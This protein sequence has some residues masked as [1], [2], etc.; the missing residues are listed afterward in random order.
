VCHPY[1]ETEIQARVDAIQDRTNTLLNR[2]AAA[3]MELLDAVA[4]AKKGGATGAQLAQVFALQRKAQWRL[5]FVAA[6]NSMGFHA[7]QETARVLAEAIDYARQGQ[8][9]AK[10]LVNVPVATQ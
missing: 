4:A 5:D 6:E 7:P 8:L 2:S 10:T 9:A 3:L 1:S